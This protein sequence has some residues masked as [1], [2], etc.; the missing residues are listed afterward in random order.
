MEDTVQEPF[1]LWHHNPEFCSDSG[2]RARVLF[3]W[4]RK[5]TLQFRFCCL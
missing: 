4:Q 2:I 5:Q 1:L 3:P